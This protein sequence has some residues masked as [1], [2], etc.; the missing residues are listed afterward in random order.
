[1]RE[2]MLYGCSEEMGP[3]TNVDD[4]TNINGCQY[5]MNKNAV[6]NRASGPGHFNNNYGRNRSCTGMFAPPLEDPVAQRNR[7]AN[8]DANRR[9]CQRMHEL[10][11]ARTQYG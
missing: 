11:V 3:N 10:W 7:E 2:E 4:G 8:R 1:M 5:N 6:G 9:L